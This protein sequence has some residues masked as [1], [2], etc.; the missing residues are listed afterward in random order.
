MKDVLLVHGSIIKAY[1][2]RDYEKIE[3]YIVIRV[4]QVNPN[5]MNRWDYACVPLSEGYR[6]DYSKY[7]K[8]WQ[9]NIIYF[10]HTDIEE[11]VKKAK[12]Y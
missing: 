12:L 10:N 6:L 1:V 11:V 7:S 9:S 3:T 8:D 2:P 5:T 4:R